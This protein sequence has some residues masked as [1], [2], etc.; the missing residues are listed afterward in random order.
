MGASSFIGVAKQ[1][2]LVTKNTTMAFFPQ[3]STAK[4]G[5]ERAIVKMDET[6]GSRMASAIA[7]GS[8]YAKGEI[9]GAVRPAS[10]PIFLASALG[11]P[12]SDAGTGTPK[13][14]THVFD[15]TVTPTLR[16]LSIMQVNNDTVPAAVDL[17]YG[18][19]TDELSVS[20]KV[21][22][23]LMF[24][25]AVFGLGVDQG[26]SAP[27]VTRDTSARFTALQIAAQIGV[28]GAALAAV[29]V[30]EFNVS[31]KNNVGTDCKVLG[32]S[33]LVD[34]PGGNVEVE[35]EFTI[36][37]TAA[38]LEHYRRAMAATPDDVAV[39]LVATGAVISGAN[40]N[41]VTIDIKRMQYTEAPLDIN[42][43]D[44]ATSIQIKGTACADA[45]TGKLVIVTVM[46][47][48]AGTLY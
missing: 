48:Q 34:L 46:N 22:E 25:A 40:A 3:V 20:A 5:L 17:F 26:Q 4:L 37:G 32:S 13:A 12:T 28:N 16:P 45:T 2:D 23:Y 27:A 38:M 10:F 19:V 39:K 36:V 33:A 44:V 47:D 24:K 29:K 30:S 15:P 43:K 7:Y 9:E 14:Y 6:N 42:A 1:S 31:I 8:G 41:S 21:D 11:A 18:C 35:V